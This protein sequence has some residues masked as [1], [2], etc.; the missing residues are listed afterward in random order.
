MSMDVHPQLQLD[1][2]TGFATSDTTLPGHS[3]AD[4]EDSLFI[5]AHT[6]NFDPPGSMDEACYA[7]SDMDDS[8]P[9]GIP[10]GDIEDLWDEGRIRLETLKGSAAFIQCLRDATLDDP[11]LG[12]SEEA[13]NRLHNPNRG[14]PQ[15]CID[16]DTRTAIELYLGNPSEATYEANR[17]IILHRLPDVN[18]PTYY[19]TGHLIAELTGIE[20][21]VHHM[22]INSCVAFT[23]PFHDLNKCPICTEPCYNQFRLESTAGKERAPHKEFHTIPI[24]L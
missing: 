18:I 21:M 9:S 24:G 22:C 19:R 12:L 17:T 4:V 5:G 6:G 1:D 2:Q 13:I 3:F 23:G 7:Y 10:P 14:Q 15:C 20:S 11:N 8:H 16:D